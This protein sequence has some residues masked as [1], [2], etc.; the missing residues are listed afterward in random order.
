MVADHN[1]S[2]SVDTPKLSLVKSGSQ[3]A[4]KFDFMKK[5]FTSVG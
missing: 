5:L 1:S 3:A 4:Q 2:H